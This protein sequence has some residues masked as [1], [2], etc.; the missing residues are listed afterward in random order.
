MRCRAPL[1]P[2]GEAE[3]AEGAA[4]AGTGLSCSVSQCVAQ[5]DFGMNSLSSAASELTTGQ[6]CQHRAERSFAGCRT[7]LHAS[8][9]ASLP[10]AALLSLPAL[11]AGAEGQ[12]GA[13]GS[14]AAL[15]PQGAPECS[16]STAGHV[17]QALALAQRPGAALQGLPQESGAE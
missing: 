9:I 8:C 14:E 2:A 4:L 13:E 5:L 15:Q 16:S 12:D 6:K 17:E 11:L 3:A 7:C 1:R 10:V